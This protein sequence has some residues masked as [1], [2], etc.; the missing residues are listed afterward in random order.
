MFDVIIPAR[1]ASTRLPGKPLADIAGR[2]MVVHVAERARESGARHIWVA[3]DDQRVAEVVERAGFDAVMTRADHPSG[4]DRLAEVVAHKNLAAQDIVVN[5][6]GDEPLIAPAL[7][8][9][10]AAMLA[11]NTDAAM[12][13][14]C[15]R[16][17]SLQDLFNPNVVKVVCD[18]RGRA[19]YFS[20]AP[21]P[22]GRDAWGPLLGD[23]LAGRPDAAALQ[24]LQSEPLPAQ[25]PCFRHIG[26]Y[27]YRVAFL[28][29][30]ATLSPSPLEEVE[31]LE[32]LRALWHGHEIAV[33][34]C[35][36]A[37][38]AGVD[39]PEDLQRVRLQIER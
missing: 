10:V 7:I 16:L 8:R 21:I 18:A 36:Q 31:A 9:D 37:P 15:H 38:A 20:R 11:G 25:F 34:V 24:R 23:L 39:T 29:L 28:G 27:A 26:I 1:F 4:T 19:R 13:T 17:H 6:Q 30:Y 5:V 14:A 22:F 35:H 32:Q 2:P 3:T 12:A 33:S